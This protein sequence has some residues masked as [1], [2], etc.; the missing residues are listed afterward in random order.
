V[1]MRGWGERS[2]PQPLIATFSFLW[3]KFVLRANFHHE[4]R[5]YVSSF[6]GSPGGDFWS[7]Y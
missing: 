6:D 1:A 2:S 4:S 5:I 3:W 7:L